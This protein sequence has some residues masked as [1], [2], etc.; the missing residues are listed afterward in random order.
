MGT[1]MIPGRLHRH[2]FVAFLVALLNVPVVRLGTRLRVG[3][4][5]DASVY[6]R[7]QPGIEQRLCR[8]CL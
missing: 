1:G 3:L 2:T 5:V 4:L 6:L 7:M 8:R